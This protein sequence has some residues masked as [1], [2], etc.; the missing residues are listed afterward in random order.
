MPI[1]HNKRYLKGSLIKDHVI[2]SFLEHFKQRNDWIDFLDNLK[3]EMIT[4]KSAWLY[5]QGMNVRVEEWPTITY[6]DL[7][8][9]KDIPLS[10]CMVVRV[11]RSQYSC[12]YS[13][14]VSLF[15]NF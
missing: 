13:H 6:K 15:L 11:G 10:S 1:P 14:R 2:K 3:V 5:W 4:W 7:E 12:Q 9:L 8:G